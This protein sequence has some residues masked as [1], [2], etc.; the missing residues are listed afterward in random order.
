MRQANHLLNTSPPSLIGHELPKRKITIDYAKLRELVTIER[1]LHLLDWHPITQLGPQ[2]RGPCP[3]HRSENSQ[4]RSFS[5]HTGKNA[6][7]CFA[8]CCGSKGN[9]LDLYAAVTKQRLYEAAL[10]LCQRLSIQP[11]GTE[12]RNP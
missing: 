7:Q 8:S 6:Y 10:D 12:K 5:A 2:L 9:Q 1:V 11:P 4:S 3:I